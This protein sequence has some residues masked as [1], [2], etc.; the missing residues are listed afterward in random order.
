MSSITGRTRELVPGYTAKERIGAGGYGEVWRAEAPGGLEKAVKLIYGYLDDERAGRELK[1]LHR[2]KEV[3]HPFLL[4]LERIE[5]VEGQLVIVME[6]A[7]RSLKDRFEECQKAG[8]PGIPREELLVYIGDTADALDYMCAN[9]SLQHLDVKPENLLILGGRVKVADFGLVKDVHDTTISLMGGLTPVYAPPE[10]FDGCPS[11][12]SDQYSLAIVFQE[13]LTGTVP[14]PGRTASQLAAQHLHSPPRLASLSPSD[15]AIVGRALAKDPEQRFPNCRTMVDALLG[16]VSPAIGTRADES[17]RGSNEPDGQTDTTPMARQATEVVGTA[18]PPPSADAAPGPSSPHTE[19]FREEEPAARAPRPARHTQRTSQIGPDQ[20]VQRAPFPAPQA[21]PPRELPPIEIEPEACGLRPTLVVGIGGTAARALRRLRRRLYHR[22]G[23]TARVPAFGMLLVDTDGKTIAR[24]GQG[25][26]TDA[27]GPEEAV[28]MPLRRP[29]DYRSRS[30]ELMAWLSRRWLY[31]IPRS[32]Q[33]EGLRPLGRLAFVDHAPQFLQRLREAL[34]AITA[35]KALADASANTGLRVRSEAPRVCVVTSISGGTGSGMALDVGYA[36]RK[37]LRDLGLDD[38]GTCGILTHA[39]GR[40]PHER[41]LAIA[42]AYACLSELEH[43]RRTGYPGDAACGL[44]A[45]P[46]DVAPFQHT[47]L[48]SLGS[49]LEE[50]HFRAAVDSIAEYLYVDAATAGGAFFDRCRTSE[51]SQSGP[52]PA[53]ASL[54]SF[55]LWHAGRSLGDLVSGAAETLSKRVI[56]RWQGDADS[57][58]A[59]PAAEPS[60]DEPGPEAEPQRPDAEQ[61]ASRW[62]DEHQLRRDALVE[63][64]LSAISVQLGDEPDAFLHRMLGQTEAQENAP[65]GPPTPAQ[66]L[67][68]INAALGP[69]EDPDGAPSP[70]EYALDA[71]MEKQREA[72]GPD[73]PGALSA[74]ILQ[75]VD[76]PNGGARTAACAADWFAGHLRSLDETLRRERDDVER[77]LDALERHLLSEPPPE[78]ARPARR[79]GIRRRPKP[80]PSPG[81]RWGDY[82]RLRL[83]RLA[84]PAALNVV[85]PLQPAVHAAADLVKSLQRELGLIGDAFVDSALA[86]PE[87][88]ARQTSPPGSVADVRARIVHRL[89]HEMPRLAAR[90]DDAVRTGYL[91]R[92]GGLSEV[93]TQ[94]GQP[95]RSLISALRHAARGVLLGVLREM[96]VTRLLLC[97]PDARIANESLETYLDTLA[98]ELSACG[99]AKRLLV[100][101]PEGLAS[102]SVREAVSERVVQGPSVVCDPDFDLVL[103]WEVEQLPLSSVAASLIDCRVDY[104][105]VASR[106]HTRIDVRWAPLADG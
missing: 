39:T 15:Q 20:P 33:T 103:C 63:T 97:P 70:L 96:D 69:R 9:Y 89:S 99:G 67:D 87:P 98:P 12:H 65:G 31:N 83:S 73:L 19:P 45:F 77:S 21:A 93:L 100:V 41:D 47:Y 53:D 52:P 36:V 59:Q 23:G 3:R 64:A 27:L 66:I 22:F 71:E 94:E 72:L 38:E 92:H 6:L 55:G 91:S 8:Q 50:S 101:L 25:D 43:Y 14:F 44:P 106:L 7:E 62:A 10:V 58:P 61:Q 40:S 104:A 2:V 24:A 4:S 79:F 49:D 74:W 35:P 46:Q 76:A 68:Q 82:W 42:N 26:P 37:V 34:V 90:L 32:L 84:L 13:M 102:D 28:A 29:A 30:K 81:D 75:W 57:A 78:P 54:R 60:P 1:A 5:V 80:S 48:L 16:R 17:D 86:P 18:D 11:L 51:R 85:R 95:R 105:Q 88:N 56:Q